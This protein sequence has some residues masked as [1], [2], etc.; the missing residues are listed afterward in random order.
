[1]NL[2]VKVE[3]LEA[4]LNREPVSGLTH[5]F[6]RYPARFSPLFARAAI[7]AFTQPGDT[8][9]DPFAGGGTTLVEARALGRRAIGTDINPLATFITHVKTSPLPRDDISMIEEWSEW[10]RSSLNLRTPLFRVGVWVEEGYQ[11]N[12]SGRKT[13]PIRKTLELALDYI[14]ELPQERQRRFVRCALLKS[15]QWALDGRKEVPKAH[16]FRKQFFAHLQEMLDGVKEFSATVRS[17]DRLYKSHGSFRTLCLNCSAVGIEHEPRVTKSGPPKLILTSPPYPG[18]YILYHRWKV[19][20]R[21]ETP[22]PFWIANTLDGNGMAY[23]T[24]GDRKTNLRRNLSEYYDQLLSAFTSLAKIANQDTWLVQ[25]IGF[26]DPLL[27]LS[28][29]LDVMREAGF[30]EVRFKDLATSSDGRL[31]RCVP[32]RRWYAAYQESA[33]ETSKEVVLFHQLA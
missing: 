14:E 4:V 31:W 32:H 20:G 28:G 10:M 6:Y 26:S 33:S 18:V 27:Q 13:W 3:F 2:S 25:M 15:A 23:Y 24:F 7:E 17:S 5:N 12:I 29:Y 21:K 22:A 9:L 1:V 8:V 19:L 11:R 30:T 16:E